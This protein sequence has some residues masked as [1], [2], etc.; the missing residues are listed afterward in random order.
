MQP[1]SVFSNP[2][3]YS[4]V[5]VVPTS[6][7]SS[8]SVS[9]TSHAHAIQVHLAPTLTHRQTLALPAPSAGTLTIGGLTGFSLNPTETPA[10]AMLPAMKLLMVSTPTD[11]G[12][13]QSEG[14]SIWV[15]RSGDVGDQLDDLVR[16]G[17][18]PD[19]IGLVEAVG[20]AGLSPVCRVY[21]ELHLTRLK[22]E[23]PYAP[24]YPAGSPTIR[25]WAI[26]IGHRL[27]SA[28]QCQPCSRY[29]PVPRRDHC[30]R[31]ACPAGWVD[32]DVWSGRRCRTRAGGGGSSGS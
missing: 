27:F 14:S 13:S 2:Y 11:K 7:P 10:E 6:A 32:E 20:E 17:R 22:G 29:F 9:T 1:Y 19:A 24:L 15:L 5:P 28:L 3:I 23:A 21:F 12:L 30:W 26:S 25:P 31:T 4:V 18:V 16:E 8:S